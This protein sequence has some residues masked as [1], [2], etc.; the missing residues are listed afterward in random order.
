MLVTGAGG[1]IGTH[2]VESLVR[3]EADV[4]GFFRYT[5][6]SNAD[7]ADGVG[8]ADVERIHGDLREPETVRRAVEGCDVVLHLGAEVAIP[9]SY[10]APRQVVET[11][12]LGTLNVLL[13]AS[14]LVVER[15]VCAS[16]SEVYGQATELPI[17]ETHPLLPQSPY[18]A[19]KA[20]ADMLALA[21]HRS[22]G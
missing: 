5:S 18:A 20:G 8:A 11:N 14:D 9:Y 6:T 13:A 21:F 1:F 3:L 4:R 7:R 2:V 17:V 15:V 19:S 16:T 10:R 12:V 22:Y